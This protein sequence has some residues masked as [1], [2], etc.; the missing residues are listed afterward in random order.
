VIE[1]QIVIANNTINDLQEDIEYISK[2][3]IEDHVDCPMCG[4]V[5][6]N[7]F[8]ERLAVAQDE[9]RCHEL[10]SQL[11]DD[12]SDTTKKI[13]QTNRHFVEAKSEF[14]RVDEILNTKRGK[15]QLRDLIENEGRK[16]AH[17]VIRA[18]IEAVEQQ[19]A[20]IDKDILSVKG[21]MERFDDAERKKTITKRYRDLMR[22]FLFD[23]EVHTLK[24][25]KLFVYSNISETGSDLPRALLAYYYSILQL[26]QENST[27]AFCPIVIDSP[28]QQDQDLVNLK[29]M[30]YFIR[31]QRPKHSQIVLGLVDDC[32]V[33]FDGDV[34]ELT[35]KY[36]LLQ[37][38]GYADVAE[39]VR[40]LLNK[41]RAAE[42]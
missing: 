37:S 9:D 41:S 7:T 36:Q 5:Y 12:L 16:E 21:E 6:K 34:I 39:D 3:E 38:R 35:D 4:A 22:S 31:D 13:E 32:G 11:R 26:M 8:E 17:R 24:H 19:I 10:L 20:E 42:D 29:K 18:D 40:D 28:N 23:V 25:E 2:H 33:D 27:A 14:A 15:L 30:L 1:A